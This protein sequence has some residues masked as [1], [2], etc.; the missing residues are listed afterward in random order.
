MTLREMD[1][2]GHEHVAYYR[3]EST[4]LRC[5]VAVYDSRRGALATASSPGAGVCQSLPPSLKLYP[6]LPT[7]SWYG[8]RHAP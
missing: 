1:D 8:S 5:I 6:A 2:R 3:D 4:G 7:P